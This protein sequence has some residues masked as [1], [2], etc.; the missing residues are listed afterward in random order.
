[1]ANA[2]QQAARNL[3]PATGPEATSGW[4]E[5]IQTQIPDE[6]LMQG[7]A[8]PEGQVWDEDF[9]FIDADLLEGEDVADQRSERGPGKVS[10]EAYQDAL[11]QIPRQFMLSPDDRK[12]AVYDRALALMGEGIK[13]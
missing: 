8:G 13:I 6:Y 11:K 10:H 4:D 3:L 9:G 7:T 2:K 5:I 1:M 12:R